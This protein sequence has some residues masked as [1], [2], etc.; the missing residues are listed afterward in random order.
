MNIPL[1]TMEAT[2][3]RHTSPEGREREGREVDLILLKTIRNSGRRLKTGT[4]KPETL[5]HPTRVNNTT[6]DRHIHM[7]ITTT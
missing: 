5:Q 6:Y 1:P 7:R 3:D 4:L 2:A